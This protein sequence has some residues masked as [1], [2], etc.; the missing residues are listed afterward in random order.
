MKTD[1][2]H[3]TQEPMYTKIPHQI[4]PKIPYMLLKH[5]YKI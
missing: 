3:T 5:S 1:S 2:L 4:I